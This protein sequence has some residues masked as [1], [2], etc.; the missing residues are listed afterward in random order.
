MGV[1]AARQV[2]LIGLALTLWSALGRPGWLELLGSY[3]FA[4]CLADVAAGVAILPSLPAR[5]WLALGVVLSLPGLRF[6]YGARERIAEHAGLVGVSERLRDRLRLAQTPAIA[7]VLLSTA[8]PQSF[9][10]H[11]DSGTVTLALSDQI[12]LPGQP[13]GPGLFR[14]DYD[15]RRDGVPEQLEGELPIQLMLES[16][17]VSRSMR[18]VTP[19]AHPRWFC[20]SPSGQRA[21]TL[22]EETDELIVID[23]HATGLLRQEVG[24]GPADCV[25]LSE[26]EIAISH[27]HAP[28]VWV[29]DLAQRPVGIRKLALEAGARLGRLAWDA[30]HGELVVAAV[31]RT[32][33]VWTLAWPGLHAPSFHALPTAPDW[34]GVSAD[35]LIFASRA[36][37][38]LQRWVREG[39]ELSLRERLD[40]GRPATSFAL[41]ADR[42]FVTVTDYR[43]AGAPPQ[44]G[45]HFVQ[46]QLLV[47]GASNLGLLQR[48]LTARRSE[49]QSKPGDVDQGASPLGLWPL[50]DGRM[51]LTFAGTAE[52]WRLGLHDGEPESV[53][54]DD[55]FYAPHGVVELADG[56][57]WVASPARGALAKLAP[58]A[59]APQLVALTPSDDALS[60]ARSE[61]LARRIGERGFYESTR[62]GIACQ[63]CHL[64]ADSDLAA[65]NLGDHRLVPTL[66]VRGLIGTAPYLRD[67]SYPRIRDLD[68]VAVKLYRGYARF[69]PGRRYALQAYVESLPRVAPGRAR[70]VE[71]ERRGYE[72]FRKSGCARC[73]SP[74][75]FTNLGQLPLA[76]LFPR[77]SS[78]LAVQEQLDVPSLLSVSATPPYL[79]DGR[80]RS[81]QAVISEHNPDDLHGNTLGLSERERADLVLF[82]ESL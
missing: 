23:M 13:V 66:S 2:F 61:A 6:A 11:A 71:R 68:E 38:S 76:A 64:H 27:A 53:R 29:A 3:V 33:G 81:L 22:S 24:D 10:I 45:N 18:V 47:I 50:H 25:F 48:S 80:A 1:R 5:A 40:L 72:V 60:S 59:S 36:D 63:S 37:A 30:S 69:Q 31:G 78:A 62:S 16:G 57:L 74:P 56:T 67:G 39:D 82:L 26:H 12:R 21:A 73:H 17:V 4:L 65:Y 8:Q 51:A 46:D 28:E 15:P 41:T 35:A 19:L 14:V 43:P 70:D 75:A 9:F 79:H 42:V 20:R 7:P 49:L 44:L 54:F 52:L 34:L 55:D 77:V 32:P 58:D